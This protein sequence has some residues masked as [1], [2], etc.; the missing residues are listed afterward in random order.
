MQDHELE[1]AASQ[2]QHI[3]AFEP[4]VSRALDTRV[5]EESAARGV[6]VNQMGQGPRPAPELDDG[7]LRL[8]PAALDHNL[9]DPVITA[10]EEAAAPLQAMRLPRLAA[11]ALKGVQPPARPRRGFVLG[12]VEEQRGAFLLVVEL[13]QDA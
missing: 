6:E 5:V 10:H 12:L 3:L 4:V 1:G 2:P 8:D 7:V 11:P 9:A 13:E